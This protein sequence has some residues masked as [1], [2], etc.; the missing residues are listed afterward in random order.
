MLAAVSNVSK[1]GADWGGY[2]ANKILCRIRG[3]SQGEEHGGQG[4][5]DYPSGCS[6]SCVMRSTAEESTPE[7]S[8]GLLVSSSSLHR[9]GQSQPKLLSAQQATARRSRRNACSSGWYSFG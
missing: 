5:R 3:N 1:V 7:L 4:M 9:Q 8:S 2:T 6:I